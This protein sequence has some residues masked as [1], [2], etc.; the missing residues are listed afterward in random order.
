VLGSGGWRWHKGQVRSLLRG[1][2]WCT[3]NSSCASEAT[4]QSCPPGSCCACSRP[5]PRC[6]RRLLLRQHSHP[7]RLC[8]SRYSLRQHSC[9][10][11]P[12]RSCRAGASNGAGGA[13]PAA[14]AQPPA[15]C[16]QA[17]TVCAN[18]TARQ[19]WSPR[20]LPAN[21]TNDAGSVQADAVCASATSASAG[22]EPATLLAPVKRPAR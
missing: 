17:G 12:R 5:A 16:V 6:T 15:G 18:A 21:A 8:T 7:R 1:R 14:P 9:R 11:C 19:R 4:R 22:C 3:R 2:V 13:L 20:L 10:W